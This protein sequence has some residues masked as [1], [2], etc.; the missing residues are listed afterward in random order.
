MTSQVNRITDE[1]MPMAEAISAAVM[2]KPGAPS[3]KA[4]ILAILAAHFVGGSAAN[5]AEAAKHKDGPD[6]DIAGW[7]EEVMKYIV[8]LLAKERH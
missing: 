3:E 5:F 2:A 1:L 7:A 8:K 4:A 6:M